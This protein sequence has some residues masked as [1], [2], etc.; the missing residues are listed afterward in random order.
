[1]V[2]GMISRLFISNDHH[3]HLL[4]YVVYWWVPL[5]P[6]LI[7]QPPAH[8]SFSLFFLDHRLHTDYS[9]IFKSIT[10]IYC[11]GFNEYTR[12]SYREIINANISH[13]IALLIERALVDKL[14]TNEDISFLRVRIIIIIIIMIC[15]I[16]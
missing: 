6:V 11:G 3:L 16:F 5:L 7:L 8:P 2:K 1:M 14:A 15:F 4:G 9:T 13:T 10:Q 12:C